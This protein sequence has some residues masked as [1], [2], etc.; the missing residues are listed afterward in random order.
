MINTGDSAAKS[1]GRHDHN[2]DLWRVV[3]EDGE[4]TVTTESVIT[5]VAA[6]SADITSQTT[7]CVAFAGYDVS[8]QPQ[9]WSIC[10][11]LYVYVCVRL[12]V[13]VCVFV[14]VHACVS[15]CVWVCVFVCACLCACV[16][17]CVCKF[18]PVRVCVFVCVCAC[19]C[20]YVSAC[21]CVCACVCVRV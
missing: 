17:A 6:D 1:P 7:V 3:R 16:R 14:C 12:R 20:A 13:C 4:Y 9:I 11:G 15:S 18:V 8:L 21:M 5:E 2:N 10:V 19:L